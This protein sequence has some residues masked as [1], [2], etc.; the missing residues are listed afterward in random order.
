MHPY[1][2]CLRKWRAGLY[3]PT[4]DP[5]KPKGSKS[6]SFRAGPAGDDSASQTQKRVSSRGRASYS[7]TISQRDED[8]ASKDPALASNAVPLHASG[9][10]PHLSD[11]EPSNTTMTAELGDDEGILPYSRGPR[12]GCGRPLE[13]NSPKRTHQEDQPLPLL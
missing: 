8:I 2:Y 7:I 9:G 11:H 4:P 13:A 10:D 1:T 5:S 12:R 6:R 3:E